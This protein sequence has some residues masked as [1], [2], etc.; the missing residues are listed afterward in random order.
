MIKLES[1]EERGFSLNGEFSHCIQSNPPHTEMKI[2]RLSY[3]K[4]AEL[5]YTLNMAK[6]TLSCLSGSKLAFH[7]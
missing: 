2:A 5:I 3:I 4:I 1:F 7:L 6:A